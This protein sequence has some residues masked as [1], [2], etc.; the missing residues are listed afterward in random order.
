MHKEYKHLEIEIPVYKDII[1]YRDTHNLKSINDAL[2][3]I[4]GIKK[5][6]KI[7]PKEPPNYKMPLE[8]PPVIMDRINRKPLPP[9]EE[10]VLLDPIEE[11]GVDKDEPDRFYIKPA[12]PVVVVSKPQPEIKP[13]TVQPLT[14][15]PCPKPYS[16]PSHGVIRRMK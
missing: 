1:E 8:L 4:I 12:P 15:P 5:H 13:K 6:I 11:N 3:Q 2:R 14:L 10:D 16:E 7:E 9:V